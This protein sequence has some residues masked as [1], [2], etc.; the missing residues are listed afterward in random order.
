MT[1]VEIVFSLLGTA[2]GSGALGGVVVTLAK[3]AGESRINVGEKRAEVEIE[4][5]RAEAAA[6]ISVYTAQ[7]RTVERVAEVQERSAEALESMAASYALMASHTEHTEAR[8]DRIEAHLGITQHPTPPPPLPLLPP[9]RT[10]SA[11]TNTATGQHP[12]VLSGA[13]ARR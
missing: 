2:L 3:R 10:R 11:G 13:A 4:G 1:N 7:L 9:E 12:N 6:R 8:L 5:Q